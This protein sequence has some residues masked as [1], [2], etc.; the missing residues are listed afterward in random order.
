MYKFSDL[1]PGGSAMQ[2]KRR[3]PLWLLF[4]AGLA[5]GCFFLAGTGLA[6]TLLDLNT[7]SA[8]QLDTLKGIGPATAKK[9]IASRPYTSVDDLAKAGLSATE[10]ETLKPLVT[11]SAAKEAAPAAPEK[12]AKPA[13]TGK[14]VD[15]NTASQAEL[16]SL[17]GIGRISADKIISGRPYASVN[18]L[19][20]AGIAAKNISQ[21][22]H[23]V[24]VSPAAKTAGPAAAPPK[25]GKAGGPA[26][27][28]DLNT[29]TQA[30]LE[31]LPGIGKSSAKKIMAHRP[32]ASADELA[33]SGLSAKAIAEIKPLVTAAGMPPKAAAPAATPGTAAVPAPQKPAAPAKG[34]AAAP[35]LAPGQMVNINTASKE[36][37]EALPE[38]GPVKAQAI[39]DNR[40]YKKIDDIMKVKGI[41]E[42][43]FNK[44]K[45][46]ITVD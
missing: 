43:T 11:V 28:V 32:Y 39:I 36:M 38:I 22:Q 45:D 21:I 33:K 14:L 8:Q 31:T 26:K 35:K 3:L 27:L 12:T 9:I 25:E 18:D 2:L 24:T 7:A 16:E 44:I 42:G 1:F 4:F 19:A 40:P 5:A 20:K 17:P 6:K 41:K 37:L 23:L 29:A 46:N 34:A 13:A 15:L 10:I 30:E